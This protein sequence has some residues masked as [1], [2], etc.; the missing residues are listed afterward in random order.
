MLSTP[1]VS[2]VLPVYNGQKYLRESIES[3]LDQSYGNFEL[4]VWDDRSEDDSPNIIASY[5]DRRIRTYSNPSNLG[6][7]KTLNLAIEETT[8]PLIRL[9]SQDDI[10]KVSCLKEEIAFL[11]GHP[12]AGMSYCAY[13]TI[14]DQGDVLRP[15]K[16]DP[17][18]DLVS[19]ALAAQ[20]MFYHGSITGNIANVMLKRDVLNKVGTFREDM[21]IAGDFEMWVRISEKYPIGFL[22]RP[23]IFLRAHAGQFSRQR[24]SYITCM[25]EE[26]TVYATLLKRQPASELEYARKYDRRHRK[27]QY[28]HFMIRHLLAGHL[29]TAFDSYRAIRGIDSP[30]PLIGLWILTA[31]QRFFKMKSKYELGQLGA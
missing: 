25:S 4:I 31:D 3:V 22:R 27:L 10:M 30:L 29:K 19:S 18:P 6:L 24:S 9:W 20:I 2:I 8:A 21:R 17:T 1:P 16:H 5:R 13:D 12:E 7:F 15:A 11:T 26:H 14:D 28:V 23:L